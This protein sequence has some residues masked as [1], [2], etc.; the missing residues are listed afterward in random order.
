MPLSEATLAYGIVPGYYALTINHQHNPVC[1][2]S[3][4]RPYVVSTLPNLIV[5]DEHHIDATE[6]AAS[7]A[8]ALGGMLT[9]TLVT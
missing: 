2:L 1:L 8:S 7:S 4:Y 3:G 5:L 9:Y 6:Q